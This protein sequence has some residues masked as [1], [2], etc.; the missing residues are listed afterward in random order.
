MRVC[1]LLEHEPSGRVSVEEIEYCRQDLR[2]TLALL[3]AMRA[4][5]CSSRCNTD[6]SA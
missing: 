1:F 5:M 4:E 2:A 6:S 3:N